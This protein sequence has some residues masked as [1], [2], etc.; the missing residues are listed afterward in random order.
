MSVL[1]GVPMIV[2]REPMD[3]EYAMPSIRAVPKLDLTTSSLSWS[4]CRSTSPVSRESPAC[5]VAGAVSPSPEPILVTS[6]STDTPIG[7]IITAVAV[8]DTHMDRKPVA[9]MN[10]ATIWEGLVPMTFTVSS[11]MRRCRFHRCMARASR[12]PPM[13][14]KMML[15]P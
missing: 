15:L 13:N 5:A 8:L 3:A 14:R 7:S 4:S 1:G 11:A 9:T 2:P 10:P 6:S 12:N